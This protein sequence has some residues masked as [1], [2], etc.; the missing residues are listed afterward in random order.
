LFC[1]IE[2]G[3][4]DPLQNGKELG[5]SNRKGVVHSMLIQRG[6]PRKADAKETKR[7]KKGLVAKNKEALTCYV[8]VIL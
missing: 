1:R 3:G 6:G 2:E 8:K 7:N 4:G 5:V